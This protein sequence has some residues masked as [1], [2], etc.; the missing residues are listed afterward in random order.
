MLPLPTEA[1]FEAMNVSTDRRHLFYTYND[2]SRVRQSGFTQQ[3]IVVDIDDVERDMEISSG[4][5]SLWLWYLGYSKC[6]SEISIFWYNSLILRYKQAYLFLSCFSSPAI[7][8]TNSSLAWEV[9][10][11]YVH[12]WTRIMKLLCHWYITPLTFRTKCSNHRVYINDA[13]GWWQFY[14]AFPLT[15]FLLLVIWM[16]SF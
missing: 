1:T 2:S 16:T 5:G 9:V 6:F 4:K 3:N 10:Q 12:G 11:K 13:I 15:Y 14:Y 8:Q 7:I